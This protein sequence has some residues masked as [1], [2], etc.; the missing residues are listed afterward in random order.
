MI[1]FLHHGMYP[2]FRY[3]QMPESYRR[4]YQYDPISDAISSDLKTILHEILNRYREDP[5][6]HLK[7]FFGKNPLY[8]GPGIPYRDMVIFSFTTFYTRHILRKN[9]FN[10]RTNLCGPFMAPSSSSA[11]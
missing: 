3:R 9:H 2:D 1:N 10:G 8:S 5:A 4:P 7:W 11:Y 6:T